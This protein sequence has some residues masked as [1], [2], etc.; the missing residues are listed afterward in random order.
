MSIL[1]KWSVFTGSPCSGKTSVLHSLR[2]LNFPVREE[3]ARAFFLEELA[4]GR[5]L[6]EI[7]ADQLKLQ[8]MFVEKGIEGDKGLDVSLPY[9]LDRGPIDAIAHYMHYGFDYSNILQ[10]VTKLRYAC[11]FYFEPLPY[12]NDAVRIENGEAAEH[13]DKCFIR[14]Y[15]ECGYTIITVPLMSIEERATFVM[16]HLDSLG[17]YSLTHHEKIGKN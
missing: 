15:E 5:T 17:I 14:A 8:N 11:V 13:L 6:E 2:S 10:N 12:Q 4:K 9:I 3:L 16:Q 7:C 1:T